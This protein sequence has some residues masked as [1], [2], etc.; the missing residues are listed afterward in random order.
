[1]VVV[2]VLT[3]QESIGVSR[4]TTTILQSKSGAK[5]MITRMITGFINQPTV[6]LILE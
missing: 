4:I 1:M 5:T 3:R 2:K 6:A